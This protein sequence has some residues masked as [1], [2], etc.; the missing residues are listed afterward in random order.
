MKL[1]NDYNQ[2]LPFVSD[3]SGNERDPSLQ[4]EQ[5][6]CQDSCKQFFFMTGKSD[7]F[8]KNYETLKT[9]RI[10]Q[11]SIRMIRTAAHSDCVI[12]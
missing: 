10:N 6:Q 1:C 5:R 7:D 3:T 8:G 2:Y 11:P 12:N 9:H 4:W